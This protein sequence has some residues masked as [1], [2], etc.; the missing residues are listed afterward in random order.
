MV[1]AQVTLG[2]PWFGDETNSCPCLAVSLEG[3]SMP[4]PFVL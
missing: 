3:G 2:Q 4:L 1:V